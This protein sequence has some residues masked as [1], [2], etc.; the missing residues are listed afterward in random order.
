MA[1]NEFVVN[2]SSELQQVLD[3]Y[4]PISDLRLGEVL[5]ERNIITREQLQIALEH[6]HAKH[7]HLGQVLVELGMATREQI[8]LALSR[9]LG[10]PFVRVAGY[11]VPPEVIA[12]VPPEVAIE[13][14][15]LP[16]GFHGNRLVVAMEN[17][18]DWAALDILRIQTNRPIEPVI[19]SSNE[20]SEALERYYRQGNEA[21][22]EAMV[23]DLDI[24]H[25]EDEDDKADPVYVVEQEAQRRPIVRLVNAIIMQ[26]IVKRASD[27]NVRPEKERV[28]IYY[29]IDGK[30][31]FSRSLNKQ[32][33]PALVSRIKIMGR[34]NI[35]ERRLPQDGAARV[36]RDGKAID[37]RISIMPTVKGESVVIRILDTSAGIKSLEQLG[38]GDREQKLL[39]RIISHNHG[40]FLTTG[41]TGSGKST[42]LYALLQEVKRGN[43][44]IITVEDP[45]EYEIAGVEQVQVKSQIGYT[46]A[47]ALRHI[48]RHDPDVVMIGEIRDL[49]TARIANKAALTGHL[50]LSTLHT[51]DAASTVT[52][53][54]DMGIEPFLLSSTL[55][56]VMA[57]R[58]IRVNCPH[59]LAEESVTQE[60]RETLG[61]SQDE[62][63]YRGAGCEECNDTG[64]LGR[65][66]VCEVLE[67]TPRIASLINTGAS[68]QAI[69][70]AA[71]AE[72]MNAL[73]ENALTLARTRKTSLEEVFS[74]RLE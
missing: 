73:T 43:P 60:V 20:I 71:L 67:I 11:P 17:P 10:I 41:P 31:H 33:L 38:L 61:I 12:L 4:H 59:C 29:R 48:L 18:L 63:F 9:K 13:H 45:V 64:Y 52:R 50:V 25:E 35:A 26:G 8:N 74:V 57:Q 2:T 14:L 51:N 15:L 49:E 24:R 47:E 53:L 19:T 27:I 54:I 42:T 3:Q 34:M 40:I 69:K 65:V 44:H 58:L 72:G 39:S 1:I 66:S 32:S 28:G 30:V 37:L 16:I 68:T 21:E 5:L 56:G 7:A 23:D 55:L 6:P 46:F 36:V 22:F 62:V 70:E